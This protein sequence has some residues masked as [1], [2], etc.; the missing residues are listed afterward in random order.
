MCHSFPQYLFNS[1]PAS[2][3][4]RISLLFHFAP[5]AES[6]KAE[7]LKHV[8]KK[9]T[10]FCE[11]HVF[12]TDV[13]SFE[14]KLCYNK[15]CLKIVKI[16]LSK[17]L[18]KMKLKSLCWVPKKNKFAAQKLLTALLIIRYTNNNYSLKLLIAFILRSKIQK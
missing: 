17:R 3:L 16:P 11:N 7:L 2:V 15:Y 13:H 5:T 12:K 14:T 18:T 6:S 8:H 1:T 10:P 4:N 9:F